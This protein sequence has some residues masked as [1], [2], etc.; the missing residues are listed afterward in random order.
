MR[1]A[2]IHRQTA[3]TNIALTLNLDGSGKVRFKPAVVFWTIC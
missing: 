1:T 3:E 2:K